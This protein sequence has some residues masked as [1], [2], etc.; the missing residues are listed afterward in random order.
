ML[1]V[2]TK[3]K[4]LWKRLLILDFIT[5]KKENEER[6]KILL[7]KNSNLTEEIKSNGQKIAMLSEIISSKTKEITDKNEKIAESSK[8]S[9]INNVILIFH[10]FDPS[11]P[12]LSL[13]NHLKLPFLYPP[14]SFNGVTSFMDGP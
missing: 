6:E 11:S 9:S 10:F 4:F 1:D 12:Q 2:T 3:F 13:K 5:F 14:P 7:S 8:E